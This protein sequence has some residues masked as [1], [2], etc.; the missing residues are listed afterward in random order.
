MHSELCER[1]ILSIVLFLVV[2]APL[3]YGAVEPWARNVIL[4]SIASMAFFWLWR[5]VSLGRPKLSLPPFFLAALL[6]LVLTTLQLVPLPGALKDFLTPDQSILVSASKP[7]GWGPLTASRYKTAL[8]GLFLGACLSFCFVLL[9]TFRHRRWVK[10]TLT[11][12]LTLGSLEALYGLVE[13]WTGRQHIFWYQKIYYLEEVTGT[14]INHNHLAGLLGPLL[15]LGIG[16]FVVRFARF[17]ADRSYAFAEDGRS[18]WKKVTATAQLIRHL[19][20]SLALPLS[21]VVL[22]A[23]ALILAQSRGGLVSCALALGLQMVLLWKLRRRSTEIVQGLGILAILAAIVA[24]A[25]GPRILT[26]F[27]YAPRDAPERFELW[28]DSARIVRD[29]PFL[30]TGLGTYRDVLPNYRPQKDFFFVAGIPQPAAINYAH[31]DFLQLLTECGFVGFGLMVWALVAT[32]RHLFSRFANHADWEVAAMGNSLTAGIVAFLLH[33]LVDFNMH[34][35]ANALMFCLLVSV[36]LFLAQDVEGH[37][38]S[39]ETG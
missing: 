22:M 9:N 2:F 13:Y 16:A 19:P 30:G 8:G 33:S 24:L 25:F 4:F 5:F 28:Q 31:N 1:V 34:I 18:A 37:S 3:A 38:R 23:V 17:V 10:I 26:R 32:L 20:V 39:L 7:A 36:A 29:Y 27:S 12:L 15:L 11:V 6:F 35:P 14:Y 21:A